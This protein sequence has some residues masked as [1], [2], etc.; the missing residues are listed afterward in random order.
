MHKATDED[1]M[2][3]A[4][5]AIT[6]LIARGNVAVLTG[7]GISTESGIPDYRGPGTLKRARSPMRFQ[8]Y[9]AT[10]ENRA[11][12]WARSMVGWK[13]FSHAMPNLGHRALV[14]LHQRGRL[15]GLITQN[16]DRLHT[17][18]GHADVIE[19]HGALAETRCLDC[20]FVEPRDQIQARLLELNP[21]LRGRSDELAPDGDARL[22]DDLL[23]A[24]NVPVCL[25]CGGTMKPNV[26]FFG[27]NVPKPTVDAAYR[28]VDGASSL[29]VV[30]SSLA[31]FSGLRFVHRA[32]ER[33]IP[34]A[35]INLGETRGDEF[36]TI[37]LDR[38][39]GEALDA[40]VRTLG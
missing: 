16:V 25:L 28:V 36:A 33:Q 29:V 9:M 15:A 12:Y 22:P 32:R 37:R 39:A 10:P 35:L 4:H 20:G 11:R 1:A 27:E 34:I 2:N 38:A 21:Q 14:A 13:R 40:I 17:R 7:A 31:V 23:H 8:D 24:F 5:D 3:A 30:G 19:L 6:Q 26:V 18:A